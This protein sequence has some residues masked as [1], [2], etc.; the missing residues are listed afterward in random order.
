MLEG[1]FNNDDLCSDL[2]GGLY[3]GFDCP[4]IEKNGMLVWSDPW[5]PRGWELTEGFV[6]KW[7]FLI[8]GCREMIEATN[9]WRSERAEE[10][11]VVEL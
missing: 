9:T 5:H 8:R 3:E 1:T 6:K 10:P 7:G 11:L 4:D 2:V